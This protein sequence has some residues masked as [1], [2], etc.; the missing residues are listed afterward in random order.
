[1]RRRFVTDGLVDATREF[2]LPRLRSGT[3]DHK[4]I[5]DPRAFQ[6]LMFGPP[7]ACR[8]SQRRIGSGRVC[9]HIGRVHLTRQRRTC[10]HDRTR[11]RDGQ[12]SFVTVLNPVAV[13]SEGTIGAGSWVFRA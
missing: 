2:N 9:G 12:P 11:L 6:A 8:R 7:S 4:S 3:K 5:D 10:P 1:M 13:I